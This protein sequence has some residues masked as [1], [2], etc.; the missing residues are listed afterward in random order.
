VLGF[1]LLAKTNMTRYFLV[2]DRHGKY[3]CSHLLCI[4]VLNQFYV[5]H[6]GDCEPL[7]MTYEEA[8]NMCKVFNRAFAETHLPWVCS[9]EKGEDEKTEPTTITLN[10]AIKLGKELEQFSQ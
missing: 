3:P 4:N 9:V 6:C 5:G 8:T 1:V 2:F 10:V 7:Y